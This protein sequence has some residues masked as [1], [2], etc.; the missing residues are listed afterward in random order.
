[1]VRFQR[2][3]W[4][5][6]PESSWKQ[7]S[8]GSPMRRLLYLV[9]LLVLITLM[10]KRSS[11]PQV[12]EQAFRNLGVPF[13]ESGSWGSELQDPGVAAVGSQ[14]SEPRSGGEEGGE[15]TGPPSR[16]DS[17]IPASSQSV[18]AKIWLSLFHATEGRELAELLSRTYGEDSEEAS[19]LLL[20]WLERM[21][22]KVDAWREDDPD[23]YQ[24]FEPEWRV[25]K[26]WLPLGGWREG[27]SDGEGERLS[28]RSRTS[29]VRD[30]KMALDQ[31]SLDAIHD[32]APWKAYE[33]R[34][35][36]RWFQRAAE[37]EVG[38]DGANRPPRVSVAECASQPR[39]YRGQWIRMVGRLLAIPIRRELA[40]DGQNPIAYYECWFHPQG[41]TGADGV[42]ADGFTGQAGGTGQSVFLYLLED[43]D[44][45]SMGEDWK[46][47]SWELSCS[48]LKRLPYASQGGIEIAPVMVGKRLERA[49]GVRKAE[50]ARSLVMP[51]TPW[52]SVPQM[53]SMLRSV[54]E[55]LHEPLERAEAN[56]ERWVASLQGDR[57]DPEALEA[58]GQILY[59][60]QRQPEFVAYASQQQKRLGRFP[61]HMAQGIVRQ[62]DGITLPTE[63]AEWFG[64]RQIYRVDYEPTRGEEGLQGGRQVLLAMKVPSLWKLG[65]AMRQPMR[66][67]ALR[68]S[69][70]GEGGLLLAPQLQWVGEIDASS[71]PSVSPLWRRLASEEWDLARLDGIR[72]QQKRSLRAEEAWPFYRLLRLVSKHGVGLKDSHFERLKLEQVIGNPDGAVVMPVAWEMELFHVQRVLLDQEADIEQFGGTQYYQLDGMAR[73]ERGTVRYTPNHS[74]GAVDPI[75]FEG[76]FPVSLV[77]SEL[78]DWLEQ[79]LAVQASGGGALSNR[80]GCRVPIRAEG[81]HYRLWEY[82]SGRLDARG[83]PVLQISPLMMAWGLERI[84]PMAATSLGEQVVWFT[85]IAMVIL[86]LV[87]LGWVWQGQRRRRRLRAALIAAQRGRLNSME[88]TGAEGVESESMGAAS[89]GQDS[90]DSEST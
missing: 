73:L 64:Q 15:E 4:Y 32:A 41:G 1:M 72:A 69:E 58:V 7:G 35:L 74:E 88:R 25:M 39:L 87:G 33:S 29:I 75:L 26:A 55:L 34:V 78:P 20:G 18:L 63:I 80:W 79:E 46:E 43:P 40:I 8:S 28:S 48:F 89:I 45:G 54:G 47:V 24:L 31:A 67:D 6:R 76:K 66:V 81:V 13:V 57:P 90:S 19:P 86:G 44:V 10:M 22:G 49:S 61:F 71:Q 9:G 37:E 50:V 77:V 14:D 12:I 2:D 59:S 60:L 85:L 11:D 83:D 27:E 16:S 30:W 68:Y 3:R 82:S 38:L 70:D 23:L 65:V 84:E 36:A 42:P 52:R 21:Q 62:V 17:P 56:R 5:S 51:L 53:A